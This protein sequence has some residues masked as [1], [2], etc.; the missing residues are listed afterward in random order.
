MFTY[1]YKRHDVT[2]YTK[3]IIAAL[4]YDV[5]DLCLIRL[6]LKQDLITLSLNLQSAVFAYQQ[7]VF[8]VPTTTPSCRYAPFSLTRS[9]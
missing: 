1:A 6:H 4:L 9:E 5:S 7:G 8:A 2:S 3:S